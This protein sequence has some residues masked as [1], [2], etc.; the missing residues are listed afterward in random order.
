[1]HND[2]LE[3]L[4][5][6]KTGH[7]SEIVRNICCD[8]F[9]DFDEVDKDYLKKFILENF[10]IKSDFTTLEKVAND[11]EYIEDCIKFNREVLKMTDNEILKASDCLGKF[12][13]NALDRI[14][15]QEA[16]IERLKGECANC[17]MLEAKRKKESC[18]I[19]QI[20]DWQKG[21]CELK[22]ELKTAKTEAIKKFAHQLKILLETK[23]KLYSLSDKDC[24]FAIVQS[25]AL[26]TVDNLVK[27]ME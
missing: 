3:K 25:T 27:E 1:M 4:L 13:R 11:V 20:K 18:L 2:R 26:K 24:E 10:Q 22:Q 9:K 23:A 7:H 5:E 14:N 21:Y 6:A 12:V 8:F 16:E 15:R 17:P 19:E